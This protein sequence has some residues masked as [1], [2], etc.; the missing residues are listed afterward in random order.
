MSDEKDADPGDWLAKQFRRDD[1][2]PV[3]PTPDPLLPPSPAKPFDWGFGTP[4]APEAPNSVP[5]APNSVPA[6]LEGADAAPPSA[7]S[8]T[9]GTEGAPPSRA[10]GTADAGEPT[11]AWPIVFPAPAEV[12][13]QAFSWSD[14]PA[15]TV[16]IPAAELP[17]AAA[18]PPTERIAADSATPIDALFGESSFQ[19]Y[20]DSL[21]ANVPDGALPRRAGPRPPRGAGA[22]LQR[23]QRIL[24]IV[25]GA[26]V[27]VLILIALFFLGT[28][29]HGALAAPTPSPTPTASKTPTPTPTPTP[30]GMAAPGV[31]KW[32]E[33]RGGE[34]IAPFTSVWAE[35]FTVVDCATPHPAQMVF[36]GTFPAT[37]A[38]PSTATPAPS[39]TPG[40]YPGVAALQAQ[41]NL[42]CTAPRVIDLSVAGGYTDIQFQ[43]AYAGDAQEWN[44]GQHDYFCFV[45]RSSGQPLTNSVAG[46]PA[47]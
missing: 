26:L 32:T 35:T 44:G 15:A 36:R 8:R 39:A 42:L 28:R 33:L 5:E 16:A 31:H 46:S 7:P 18:Q 34:C 9:S 29:L 12:P 1:A 21:L 23:N 30:T 24:I 20:D 6:V 41:I 14:D 17:D 2:E 38:A 40:G 19:D 45:S 3:P 37:A 22:P 25:A 13:T 11:Q 4:E 10:S 47:K 43:G 27:A